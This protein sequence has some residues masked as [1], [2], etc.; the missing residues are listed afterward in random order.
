MPRKAKRQAKDKVL[1][2]KEYEKISKKNIA[3]KYLISY[4]IFHMS[5]ILSSN[6]FI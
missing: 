3:F 1:Q 4:K 5:K 2:F 6:Y